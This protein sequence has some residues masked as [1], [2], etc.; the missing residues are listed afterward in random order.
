MGRKDLHRISIQPFPANNPH[1]SVNQD[2][3]IQLQR[4]NKEMGEKQ[5]PVIVI[6]YNDCCTSIAMIS[7]IHAF[8]DSVSNEDPL[9][10][11]LNLVSL[12]SEP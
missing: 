9:L 5:V 6:V 8:Q 1:Y 12:L 7:S 2:N 4:E 3:T 10:F 11:L